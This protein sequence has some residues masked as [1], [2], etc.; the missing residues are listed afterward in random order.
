MMARV[1][2][3]HTGRP[4]VAPMPMALAF[5][6][7]NLAALVRVFAV[8]LVPAWYVGWILLSGLLWVL[9]FGV[10]AATYVPILL[11]PRAD[12]RPD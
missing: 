4:M 6:L 7:L 10:F 1:A 3:G 9:V 12:G 2:L 8:Y 11:R 5:G